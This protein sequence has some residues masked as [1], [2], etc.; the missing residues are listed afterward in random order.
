MLLALFAPQGDAPCLLQ[1]AFGTCEVARY[2]IEVDIAGSS[3]Q[4]MRIELRK[5]LA[6][7]DAI[8]NL[9]AAENTRQFFGH[10]THFIVELLYHHGSRI[11]RKRVGT[12]QLHIISYQC[13]HH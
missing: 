11:G 7:K 4:G 8:V 9:V 10:A 12:L 13:A 5:S 3:R 6:L 1:K 2:T